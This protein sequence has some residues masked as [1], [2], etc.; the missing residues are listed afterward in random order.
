MFGTGIHDAALDW[1]SGRG[2]RHGSGSRRLLGC[3]PGT[4]TNRVSRQH[5]KHELVSRQLKKLELVSGQLNI[6]LN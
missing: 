4:T 2:D 1:Y 3:H 5:K 6:N